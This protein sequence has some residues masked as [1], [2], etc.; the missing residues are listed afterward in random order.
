MRNNR[1]AGVTGFDV[2]HSD[3]SQK[4][5]H[6]VMMHFLYTQSCKNHRYRSFGQWYDWNGRYLV[7]LLNYLNVSILILST[8]ALYDGLQC[9]QEIISTSTIRLQITN[10]FEWGVF[11]PIASRWNTK[12]THVNLKKW[13]LG[14]NHYFCYFICRSTLLFTIKLLIGLFQSY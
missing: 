5:I 4:M 1:Q 2:F 3:C 11:H 12:N 13:A 9:V 14:N 7:D 8:D 10:I 6:G